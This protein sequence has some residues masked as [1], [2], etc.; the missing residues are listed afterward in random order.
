MFSYALVAKTTVS[1]GTTAMRARMSS[2]SASGSGD[3]VEADDARLR[4]VEAL[5]EREQR[6]LARA[7]RADE[8]DRLA[9]RDVE[10]E[11][12]HRRRVGLG[13]VVEGDVV[14]RQ[15]PLRRQR[16]R[17]RVGG[18]ADVGARGEQFLDPPAARRRR[19]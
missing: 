7:R 9:R 6:R 11:V 5:D 3:A 1:C 12:D 10:G 16:Q 15:P 13:R 4:V 19:A 14:E 8:R 2:G 18:R 17:D